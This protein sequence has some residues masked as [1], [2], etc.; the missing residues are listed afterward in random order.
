[1]RPVGICQ[2]G[3]LDWPV[4]PATHSLNQIY[5]E[6]VPRF[7]LRWQ[8]YHQEAALGVDLHRYKFHVAER[9]TRKTGVGR[10]QE[11]FLSQNRSP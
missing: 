1:M 11:L 9:T 3:F 2:H 6:T 7:A 4:F 10:S 5:T 8:P